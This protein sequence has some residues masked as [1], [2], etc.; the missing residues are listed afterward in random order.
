MFVI[1]DVIARKEVQK[2]SLDK[3]AEEDIPALAPVNITRLNR[4]SIGES[5]SLTYMLLAVE[6]IL[7][8]CPRK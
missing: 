5:V 7:F 3:A 2:T 4:S 8:S 1:F 6:E